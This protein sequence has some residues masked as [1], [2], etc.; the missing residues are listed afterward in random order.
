MYDNLDKKIAERKDILVKTD[1]VIQSLF[2]F[3]NIIKKELE[4]FEYASKYKPTKDFVVTTKPTVQTVAKKT[5]GKSK[6]QP[7]KKPKGKKLSK[8]GKPLGRPR[9]VYTGQTLESVMNPA[10]EE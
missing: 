1:A 2:A 3:K 10:S 6:K 9:K 4:L 7:V 8:N 5:R